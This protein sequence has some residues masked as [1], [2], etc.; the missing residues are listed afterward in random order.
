MGLSLGAAAALRMM[1]HI[2]EGERGAAEGL[3][4]CA[5]AVL[6]E[7]LNLFGKELQQHLTLDRIRP[8]CEQPVVIGDVRA[9]KILVR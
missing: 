3:D 8:F 2:P 7:A 5:P 9:M 6:F 4:R 1:E